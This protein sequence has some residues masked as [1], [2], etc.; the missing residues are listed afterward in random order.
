MP[1]GEAAAQVSGWTIDFRLGS[2]AG[3]LGATRL[4]LFRVTT[5]RLLWRSSRAAAIA[6][7]P[8]Q[9]VH[10]RRPCK[11]EQ[12]DTCAASCHPWLC[13]PAAAAAAA[14]GGTRHPTLPVCLPHST[15]PFN[16]SAMANVSTGPVRNEERP[17]A[18]KEDACHVAAGFVGCSDLP[19]ACP[20]TSPLELLLFPSLWGPQLALP[21]RPTPACTPPAAH[22]P[23][24][25]APPRA[26]SAGLWPR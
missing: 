21:A 22:P 10:P 23:R 12:H 9:A 8:A 25:P 24:A 26:W 19:H 6:L 20:V 18:G 15:M 1:R 2:T 13:V 4:L 5:T 14:V 11:L 16:C 3:C 7:N 17:G